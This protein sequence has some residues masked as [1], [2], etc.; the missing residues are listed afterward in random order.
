MPGDRL[1]LAVRVSGQIKA[2]G[3]FQ[4]LGDGID[5]LAVFVDDLVL[6]GKIVLGIDGT[7]FRHKVAHM[8]IGGQYLKVLAEIFLNG[9]RLGRRFHDHEMFAHNFTTKK[10]SAGYPSELE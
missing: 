2:I 5:M 1:A 3:L 6:H 9:L 4:R 10:R 7:L 8:T